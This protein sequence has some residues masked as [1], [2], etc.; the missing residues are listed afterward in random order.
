MPIY[1]FEHPKTGEKKEV[2]MSMNDEHV[3]IDESGT[4]WNRVFSFNVSVKSGPL[5][6]WSSKDYLKRTGEMKGT[7]GD[8][9]DLSKEMSIARAKDNGGVDPVKQKYE[10][11]YSKKRKGFKLPKKE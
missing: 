10:E 11:E 8:M 3:F 2:I 5:D 9:W 6:P 4:Q 7:V 1:T